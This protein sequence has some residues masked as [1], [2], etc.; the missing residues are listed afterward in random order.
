MNNFNV[1][2]I[3]L[4]DIYQENFMLSLYLIISKLIFH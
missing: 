4:Y 2:R 1:R 3:V